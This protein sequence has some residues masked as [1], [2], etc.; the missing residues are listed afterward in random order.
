M[1]GPSC[2]IPEHGL[3]KYRRGDW[4]RLMA[5]VGCWNG[6]VP[7]RQAT[8]IVRLPTAAGQTSHKVATAD[9]GKKLT[10]TVTEKKSG[11]VTVA[12]TSAPKTV[13]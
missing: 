12:K 7:I 13:K 11:Y 4:T 1:S 9:S 10:V 8:T 2:D 3:G 5:S 6:W